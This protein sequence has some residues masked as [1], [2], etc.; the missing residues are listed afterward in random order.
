MSEFP[1]SVM[2]PRLRAAASGVTRREFLG[3]ACAAAAFFGLGAA[4]PRLAR[5]ESS[6]WS[7][8]EGERLGIREASWYKKLDAARVQ[9]ELCPR[10]CVVDDMERGYCGVRENRGG[11]YYTL[12]YGRPCSLHVDPVE[13]KPLFHF[14]PGRDAFSLATAGCN[15]EC[16]FC[17]NWQISQT[18]PEDL[19]AVDLPPARVARE[20]EKAGAPILAYTYTEPVV[21]SE[22]MRDSAVEGRKRGIRS[23]M[24]SNG[25][26]QQQALRDLCRVLDAVKIDLKAFR[27]SFYRDV[28][29]GQLEPVLQTLQVLREERMWFE[30]VYLV[31]PTLNDDAGEIRRMSEWIRDHLGPDVPLHFSRFHPT[32]KIQNLPDTPVATLEKARATAMDTGLHYVYL[33]NVVGH[34][35]ESTYCPSCGKR[36]IHRVG[37]TVAENLL[38]GS[39]CPCGHEIPGVWS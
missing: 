15:I 36:V 2:D 3:R 23:V 37:F 21:F 19:R 28:C 34:E 29:D 30:I 24:I 22:Y 25:Y 5:G 9:C 20:A 39:R 6:P 27:D 10:G 18:R 35:G 26:V 17:Q 8:A 12:V 7:D 33:G 13:K 38:V 16:Q 14:L 32:Y 31:V 11:T 4:I 1:D